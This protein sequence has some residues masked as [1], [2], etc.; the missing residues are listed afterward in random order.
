[1]RERLTIFAVGGFFAVTVVGAFAVDAVTS[2]R[3]R[4]EAAER[5]TRN[6]AAQLSAQVRQLFSSADQMLRATM[7]IHAEW[8]Q[9]PKRSPASGYRHIKVLEVGSDFIQRITWTDRA[10]NILAWSESE[11]PPAVNIAD[12]PHFQYH[13]DRLGGGLY[14]GAPFLARVD[15]SLISAIARRIETPND[16]F[17][18][19][20]SAVINT[21]YLN[22]VLEHYHSDG[23]L[24]I[25]LFLRD[26]HYLSRYPNPDERIGLSRAHGALFRE[27]LPLAPQMT[28]HGPSTSTGEPH[29]Y[30]YQAVDGLVVSVSMPYAVALAPWYDRIRTTGIV[31]GFALL[32]CLVATG[33][34]GRQA[35]RLGRQERIAHEARLAAE[36]ANRSKSE[37][38]AHMSHELR[39]PMNAVI[40]FTEM[41][42]KEVFGPVGSPKYREYLRDIAVS[43]QH[44][45]H[46]VNNILDLAKVE[47]GKWTM[48]E[49]LIDLAELCESTLQMV[50][51]RAR[52]AGV[53]L[54][55]EAGAARP[56]IRADR[57]LMRQI[58]I[59]LLTN[60]IKFTEPGGS[61]AIGWR[62]RGDGRVVLS[63][64]DT[65][66]GMTAEDLKRV[67]EPFG[68]GSAELARARHDTGL[69]LS[70]CRQFAEMQ[71]GRLEIASE[72]GTGTTIAVILPAKRVIDAPAKSA[73][74]A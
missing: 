52:S 36:H 70:I 22:R 65:G 72:P 40:G 15:G 1:V 2:R 35:R 66:V 43:G 47:S 41:M 67:Q 28:F 26:G 10:G 55:L 16:E 59:N 69:G 61:V 24:H 11:N 54:I 29:V 63:V 12:R 33:F 3:E 74:A 42:T 30:S 51:E 68:R 37:F 71:G 53:R 57:R 13:V 50:R 38:L 48:D 8:M 62:R 56:A 44:L 73:A 14:I 45:L 23:K 21:R 31:T 9:D 49:E 32:G 18:G 60:G 34:I 4:M 19:I 17:V 25:S 39:T 5:E 20:V 27:K 64:A 7:L 6:A 58:L 46:V